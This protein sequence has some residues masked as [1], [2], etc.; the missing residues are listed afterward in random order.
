MGK[1]NSKH[2]GKNGELELVKKFKELGADKARRSA[3]FHGNIEE[4]SPDLLGVDGIH[5]ESKRVERL[6]IYEAME[7]ATRDSKKQKNGIPT[8]FHRKNGKGWL[9]IM[10]F[11]DWGNMW[12]A[13][14][15]IGYWEEDNDKNN[16]ND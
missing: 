11:E 12:K 2:K 3:Q 9:V 13:L 7:Q 5:V 4:G 16:D 1:I 6:Q 14:K 10:N 8:V 15:D